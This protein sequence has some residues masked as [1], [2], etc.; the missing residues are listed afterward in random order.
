MDYFDT[1]Q[2]AVLAKRLDVK[3]LRDVLVF[4]QY[5]HLETIYACNSRCAMCSINW[6]HNKSIKLTDELFDKFVSEVKDYA[7]WIKAICLQRAGEATLDPKLPERV[8]RLKEVGIKKVFF[9]T[10]GQ[11]LKPALSKKLVENGLDELMISIDAITN[12]TYKK[13]RPNLDFDTVMANALEAVRLRDE[14]N[15]KMIIRVRLVILDENKHEVP[16]WV[17]FWEEKLKSHDRIDAKPVHTFG[18]QLK[19][20]S[21]ENVARFADKPCVSLFST[22]SIN[23]D[24]L[25]GLC[26]TDYNERI[27]MG[28]FSKNTLLEIWTN[29]LFVK[30]REYHLTK[31]RNNIEMC[32]GCDIWDREQSSIL[33]HGNNE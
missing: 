10:N 17:S 7:H 2:A 29:E 23:T 24:G 18:N 13:I 1:E 21:D 25:V 20:E 11:L 15:P 28:D 8:K 22:M 9:S 33:E 32:C 12:E 19:P 26:G 14:I 30:Y 6:G 27:V 31:Q 3:N 16:E 4:P 5:L